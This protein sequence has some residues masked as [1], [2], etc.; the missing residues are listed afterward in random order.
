MVD[1]K[2]LE[3]LSKINL[4][5]DEKNKADDFFKFWIE[6]FDMLENVDTENIEPLVTVS[7]LVNVMR[8]DTAYKMLSREELLENAPEQHDGYFI[9]PRILE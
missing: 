1:L 3:S 8:E 7:S 2:I 6:K 9:V 4:T 5:D